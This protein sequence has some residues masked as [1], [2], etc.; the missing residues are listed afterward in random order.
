MTQFIFLTAFLVA[1]P[2][3]AV[4][5]FVR[6]SMFK[7]FDSSCCVAYRKLLLKGRNRLVQCNAPI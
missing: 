3:F 2:L 1:Q 7:A 5:G 6:T 4:P